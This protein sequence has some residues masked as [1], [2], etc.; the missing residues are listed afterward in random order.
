MNHSSKVRVN[1]ISGLVKCP[2]EE[3]I[4][5]PLGAILAAKWPQQQKGKQDRFEQTTTVRA[6]D[7]HAAA[8]WATSKKIEATV[9]HVV[10]FER[11][12]LTRP[13]L[14]VKS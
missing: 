7:V 11:G 4:I 8:G 3:K 6:P 10:R 2:S 5:V 9:W 13:Y 1:L 14:R 12:M